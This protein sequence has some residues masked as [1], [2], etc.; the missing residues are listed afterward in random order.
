[1]DF[2]FSNIGGNIGG[3]FSDFFSNPQFASILGNIGTQAYDLLGR[4]SNASEARAPQ[5]PNPEQGG[6]L[7]NPQQ[8]LQ[9]NRDL[10]SQGIPSGAVSTDFYRGYLPDQF[11][12]LPPEIIMQM[13]RGQG[14]SP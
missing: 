5:L 1:M 9:V 8:A 3:F 14:V 12:N 10:Q 4:T 7:P 6:A 13:I 2:D 11:Q